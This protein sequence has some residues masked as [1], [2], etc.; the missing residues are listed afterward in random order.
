MFKEKEKERERDS[1]WGEMVGHKSLRHPSM[2][3]LPIFSSSEDKLVSTHPQDK[4]ICQA[5]SRATLPQIATFRFF[6]PET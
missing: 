4:N 5:G 2:S 3:P 6:L 1:E